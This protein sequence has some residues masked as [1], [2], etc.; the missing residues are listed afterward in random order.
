MAQETQPPIGRPDIVVADTSPLIHLSQGNAL[1]LL[2]EIGGAVAVVDM[3]VHEATRDLAKPE[4]AALRAWIAEGMK[5][6]SNTPVRYE[7]TETGRV[8]ETALKA[9]PDYRMK[10]GGETAIVQWLVEKVDGTDLQTIVIYENGKVPNW[11][12]NRNLDADIDVLTTR[13]FLDL[14]ERR[15]LIGSA[16]ALWSRIEKAAPTANPRIAATIARRHRPG[17]RRSDDGQGL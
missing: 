17:R 8:F 9:D 1:H 16:E 4:A 15:H 11:I 3:V 14:A 10:D 2:H 5:P 13:A 6:G 7:R 12:N